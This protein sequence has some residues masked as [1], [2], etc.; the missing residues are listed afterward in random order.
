MPIR[1]TDFRNQVM[2]ALGFQTYESNQRAGLVCN[3]E[4]NGLADMLRQDAA[5]LNG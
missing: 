2:R 1:D 4:D 5:D 3:M